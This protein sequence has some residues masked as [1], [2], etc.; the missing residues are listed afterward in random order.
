[1]DL[2]AGPSLT[3][4]GK[5]LG[6]QLQVGQPL[7]PYILAGVLGG[8]GMGT[9]FRGVRKDQPSDPPV[10]LKVL[11]VGRQEQDF[12]PRFKREAELY[13]LLNHPNI[14]SMLDYG[15]EDGVY[16]LALEL[17]DGGTLSARLSPN[18]LSL[19][20]AKHYLEPLFKAV[21]FAHD[22]GVVHRDLKPDNVMLTSAGVLRVTDFGLGRSLTSK[23]LTATGDIMGTP[24]YMAPEQIAGVHFEPATDQYALGIIAF[25][26]L[27][28][29]LPFEAPDPMTVIFQHV[30]A[31]P[32]APSSLRAD[33]NPQI[34]AAIL[35]MLSKEP[36]HRYP[37]VGDAWFALEKGLEPWTDG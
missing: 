23:T 6:Q 13:A 31:P 27:T 2:P 19:S 24:S 25:Q 29:H 28:G 17:M 20:E 16:F 4:L 12:F 14:V 36:G 1:M 30:S 33:L 32:P 10:A 18:G 26:L 34:D 15:E 7:G 3:N 35:R 11:H 37:N 8:G 9:V 21:Q 5:S 22:K